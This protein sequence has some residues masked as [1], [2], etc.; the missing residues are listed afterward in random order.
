M[1]NK[2]KIFSMLS[3]VFVSNG[4]LAEECD[5]EYKNHYSHVLEMVSSNIDS[6]V[7]LGNSQRDC[8]A[9]YLQDAKEGESLCALFNNFKE[10]F[11]S[12]P[13]DIQASKGEACFNKLLLER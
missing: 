10:T 5:R 7:T 3:I 8:F 9:L 1:F 2:I 12:L 13:S 4:V 6:E 11:L